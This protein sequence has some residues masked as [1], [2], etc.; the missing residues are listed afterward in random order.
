MCVVKN[1]TA[2]EFSLKKWHNAIAYH[3]AREAQAAKIIRIA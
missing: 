1:S 3:R 2:F